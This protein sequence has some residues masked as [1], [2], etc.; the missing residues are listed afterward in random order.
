MMGVRLLGSEKGV[1]WYITEWI[2][3]YCLC[4]CYQI[5]TEDHAESGG[6]GRREVSVGWYLESW[7]HIFSLS[8]C[9][10]GFVLYQETRVVYRVI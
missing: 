7:I 9:S 5:G 1:G 6:G 2:C 8:G 3:C 10:R 4:D